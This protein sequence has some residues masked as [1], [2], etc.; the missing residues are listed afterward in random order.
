MKK[1]TAVIHAD[2][3]G[4]TTILESAPPDGNFEKCVK[5]F[6]TCDKPGDLIYIRRG[7]L[8]GTRTINPT[9]TK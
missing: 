1:I 8:Y 7:T 6:Q 4:K 2:L 5:A 3:K 9:S